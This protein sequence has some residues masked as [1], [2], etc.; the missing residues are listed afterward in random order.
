MLKILVRNKLVMSIINH[1]RVGKRWKKGVQTITFYSTHS[2]SGFV[3]KPWWTVS[4]KGSILSFPV[5]S[6]IHA[7]QCWP[8]VSLSLPLQF[9]SSGHS[10]VFSILSSMLHSTECNMTHKWNCHPCIT[11]SHQ[12]PFLVALLWILGLV[13]LSLAP[14][15]C[16]YSIILC[17][18]TWE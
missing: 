11:F 16:F 13:F 8:P 14:N 10:D 3:P 12:E 17:M 7:Q 5:W 9:W 15:C 4:M 2:L 6:R 1:M 18:L